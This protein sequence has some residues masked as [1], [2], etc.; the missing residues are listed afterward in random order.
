MSNN[1]RPLPQWHKLR[2]GCAAQFLDGFVE[3]LA[4]AGYTRR[5]IREHLGG[6]VHLG[7]WAEDT[8]IGLGGINEDAVALFVEHLRVC[9]CNK[10][11]RC[12]FGR[13]GRSARL[14]L[15]HLRQ[16][17]AVRPAAAPVCRHVPPI[18]A[19]FRAWMGRHR[20]VTDTTLDLYARSILAYLAAVG[21][22]PE[23][24]DVARVRA[25]II[26][27]TSGLGRSHAKMVV[28]AVRSFLR[29]LSVE[30]LCAY[31]ARVAGKR[32]FPF[33]RKWAKRFWS[34]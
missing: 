34:I 20:G 33:H 28:T 27:H 30:G 5:T 16:V 21:E 23:A 7:R 12:L 1:C 9:R 15:E 26:D 22:D 19:S 24:Y 2:S 14:F 4:Q 17:G 25:F 8:G 29:F 3:A 18:L 11:K 31:V 10:H 6:A 32:D 13:A